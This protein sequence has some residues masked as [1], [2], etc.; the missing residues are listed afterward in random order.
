M[1]TINATFKEMIDKNEDCRL[2]LWMIGRI[3]GCHLGC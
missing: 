3:E 1:T 2:G